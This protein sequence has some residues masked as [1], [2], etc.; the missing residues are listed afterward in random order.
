MVWNEGPVAVSAAVWAVSRSKVGHFLLVTV[1]PAL[2]SSF[3]IARADDKSVER[4][5]NP[6]LERQ[7]KAVLETPVYKNAH[8]GLL[9]VDAKTGQTLYERDADQLFAPLR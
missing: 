7:I 8:W 3:G 4:E 1:L 6:V 5:T 9:V 2:L